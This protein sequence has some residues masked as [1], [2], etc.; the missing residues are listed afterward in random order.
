MRVAGSQLSDGLFQWAR[1]NYRQ[2]VKRA[3][4]DP[5][6]H[7]GLA[8]AATELGRDQQA[9]AEVARALALDPRHPLAHVLGGYLAQLRGEAATAREHYEQYLEIEPQGPFAPQV[10][11]I[12]ADRASLAAPSFRGPAA[13]PVASRLTGQSSYR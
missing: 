3:P 1:W 8:V 2:A 13:A 5:D 9:R 6:A 4:N 10:R 7:F 11:A 12:L